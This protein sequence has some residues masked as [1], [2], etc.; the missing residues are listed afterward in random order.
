MKNPFS[1]DGKVVFIT[2]S[3]RGLGW[4]SARAAAEAG[5]TVVLHGRTEEAGRARKAEL[6]ADGLKADYL[7]FDMADHAAVAAAVP[8]IVER[9]G[10]IWGLVNNAG[11][12]LHDSIWDETTESYEKIMAVHMIAPF[13]LTKAAASEMKK[14]DAN[15]RGRIVN[16]SSIAFTSP[17]A[18]ICNYT[19]AKGAIV[20]FTRA[21]S[22]ELGRFGIRVN[23]IAPGYFVTDI[24]KERLQDEAFANKINVRT[25][26]ARWGDPAELG[27]PTVFLLSG[28]SS[29]VSGQ[30]LNVDGGMSHF[31]HS[32]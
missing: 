20:G 26:A 6:E 4:A 22:A 3:T 13:I 27:G 30:L 15:D 23:A 11:M 5:A 25:P 10:S 8:T 14:S 31:L 19:S 21:A 24:N 32:V 28:A 7:A 18:G 12:L 1:L 2:G 29:Y 9:H 16:V 17:R